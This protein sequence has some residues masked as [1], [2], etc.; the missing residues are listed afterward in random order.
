MIPPAEA[1]YKNLICFS[2]NRRNKTD[3]EGWNI[4]LFTVISVG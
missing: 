1:G 2:G 3:E 4:V